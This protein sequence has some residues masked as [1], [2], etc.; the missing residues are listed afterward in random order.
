MSVT[1]RRPSPTIIIDG[2]PFFLAKSGEG[3]ISWEERPV[4]TQEGDPMTPRRW[5]W[6]DWSR[7]LG[8][9]RGL[10]RGSV[11]YA[12][13]AYLGSIGRILP[14]PK[15]ET[16]EANLDDNV[17]AFCEVDAP[18]DRI[19]AGGGTKVA[20]INPSTHAVASTATLTGTVLSLQPWTGDQ[21]AVAMGDSNPYVVRDNAGSYAQNSISK[22]ARAFGRAGDGT[23]ARGYQNAW[24]RNAQANITSSDGWTT[25][26][27]IGDE[28]TLVHQVFGHNRWD[29]VYKAE[30]V[31][32]FEEESSEESNVLTD[33]VAFASNENRYFFRWYDHVFFCSLAGLYRYIQAAAVR[34]VGLEELPA[35]ESELSNAY[36]TAGAA[37][38]RHMYVAYWDGTNTYIVVFRRAVEG[39]ASLGSPFTGLSVIDK[40]SRECRAM[41]ISSLSGDPRLYYGYGTDVRHFE[42]SR[43]GKPVSYRD[44]GSV[45]VRFSPSSLGSPLTLKQAVNVE[46]IARNITAARNIQFAAAWDG[47]S[48][49]NVGTA[50]E[51]TTNTYAQRSWTRGTNDEGRELQLVATMGVDDSTTPPEIREV[52]ID[53]EERPATVP[54]AVVALRLRDYDQEG[55]VATRLTAREQRDLLHGYVDGAIVQVTDPWGRQFPA[56]LSTYT[57]QVPFNYRGEEVQFDAALSIRELSYASNP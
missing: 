46:V 5:A 40:F 24:S 2:Q 20:E 43:D 6:R 19:L 15:I 55:G 3:Y 12:E 42:L 35:N 56:R 10:V 48:D 38:G 25:D 30:G 7:G 32:T 18:A 44:S 39:D 17:M 1:A 28:D 23:L 37:F 9:S 22:N 13:N 36:P 29:L 54:G 41:H 27:D 49:N 14:G 34:P 57:G 4:Q 47:G 21:V 45:T 26:Y 51:S 53:F 33:L 8:D 16:I 11:E 50:I 52:A 31:Y